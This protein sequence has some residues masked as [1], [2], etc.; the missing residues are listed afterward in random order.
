MTVVNKSGKNKEA[1]YQVLLGLVSENVQTML[2]KAGRLSVQNDPGIRNVY[3]ADN[4]LFK[5]KNLQ[6]ILK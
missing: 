6:A 4:D 5:G 1:A 3:G 2:S